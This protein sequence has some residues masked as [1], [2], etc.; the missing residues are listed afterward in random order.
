MLYDGAQF[1][2]LLDAT[3]CHAFWGAYWAAHAVAMTGLVAAYCITDAITDAITDSPAKGPLRAL[4][5]TVKDLSSYGK[6]SPSNVPDSPARDMLHVPKVWFAHFYAVGA[7][8][9]AACLLELGL[10]S[11]AAVS[12]LY[13]LHVTRRLL[14]SRFVT[15]F[16][17]TAAMHL[18][19][20]VLGITYYVAVP[21]TL[22]CCGG[23]PSPGSFPFALLAVAFLYLNAAQLQCHR[24]LAA[25]RPHRGGGGGGPGGGPGG[26][27]RGDCEYGLPRDGWFEVVSCPHYL[28]EV[29][30]YGTLALLCGGCPAA[31]ALFAFVA[32]ELAFAA[33]TQHAWYRATFSDY[34]LE[35]FA[36]YPGL[37]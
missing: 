8:A 16:S 17:P 35:R 2:A 34:P 33:A 10:G 21:L 12:W 37:L 7:V 24:A 6:T 13:Q 1:P 5:A 32:V 4:A 3:P 23:G 25:L 9:N 18:L 36:I 27:S 15:R 30:L 26:G 14:E 11:G 31:C 19:H 28:I 20:Y 22:R 29:G